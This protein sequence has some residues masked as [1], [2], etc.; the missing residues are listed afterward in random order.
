[1]ECSQLSSSEISQLQL[2]EHVELYQLMMYGSAKEYIEV[3]ESTAYDM[4][5]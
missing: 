3:N 1:M 2:Q 5:F 4:G